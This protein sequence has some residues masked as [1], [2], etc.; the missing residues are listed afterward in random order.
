[1]SDDKLPSN[2]Y[3]DN[4]KVE[5]L[6]IEYHKTG[7]TNIP[8]R[9]AIM[10]NASELIINVIRTHNLHTIYGGKEESSFYDLF[11]LAWC[12]IES[13]LYKF[14]SAPGHSKIFNM[15]SQVARTVILAAIKKDNRDRKN[16]TNYRSHLDNVAI[17]RNVNFERFMDEARDLCQYNDE[18]MQIINAIEQLYYN[19]SKPHEGLINKLCEY[20]D[21]SRPKIV[22]FIKILRV[23]SFEFTDSPV[24]EYEHQE[25]P[26]KP[27]TFAWVD[28]ED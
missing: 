24:G 7:C 3:F 12:Q 4:R 21:M 13:T 8:L 26:V 23:F 28:P 2:Y 27:S 6:L 11:Q 18:H 1:M 25:K 10:K 14:N 9:D 17:R 22:K 16:S 20:T 15:W 5:K 19:D